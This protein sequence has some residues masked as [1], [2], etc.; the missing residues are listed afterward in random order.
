MSNEP[1]ACQR[2]LERREALGQLRVLTAGGANVEH[3]YSLPRP[4]EPDAK[5]TIDPQPRLAGGSS[6]NHS[7]RLLAMGARVEP[8][9]PA[10]KSDPVSGVIVS[11]LE[12]AEATGGGSFR[13][14]DLLVR[15]PGLT[16]PFTTIIRHDR[17]RAVLNEFSPAMMRAYHG[18]VER[19]LARF[20][21]RRGAVP[22]VLLLGHVHADRAPGPD[23][24]V[25]YDGTIT[26]RL[27]THPG[28]AGT[29]RYVN[30]GR[31]QYELGARHWSR[32]L[33]DRVDVFQLD[34]GEIRRF[35]R[36]AALPDASL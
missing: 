19:H 22:R 27:L 17:S 28:L 35:C 29:R 10:A 5:Y 20:E 9:L 25:G 3:A 23:R 34:I 6:V 13:R 36:Y 14:T 21:E 12:E 18:H 8:I 16:T 33:R 32:L 26:A 30:F 11:A 2:M 15:G 1:A 4:F 31:A 24:E 7:C